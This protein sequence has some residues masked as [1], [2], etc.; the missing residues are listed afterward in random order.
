MYDKKNIRY[1][2]TSYILLRLEGEKVR[3]NLYDKLKSSSTDLSEQR[4]I[5]IIN[6]TFLRSNVN[7]YNLF[8][9]FIKNYKSNVIYNSQYGNYSFNL[10]FFV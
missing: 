6:D 3:V 7:A 10:I 2:D 5:Q 8:V 9:H 4:R 1:I